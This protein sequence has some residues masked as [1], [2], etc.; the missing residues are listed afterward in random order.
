M[1]KLKDEINISLNEKSCTPFLKYFVFGLIG[2]CLF[3]IYGQES[4]IKCL[5][6]SISIQLILEKL[7]I[8]SRIYLGSCCFGMTEKNTRTFRWGGFWDG[9][10]HLWLVSEFKELIDFTISLLHLHPSNV[11]TNG[12]DEIPPLWWTPIE[13]AIPIFRYLPTDLNVIVEEKLEGVEKLK[14]DKLKKLVEEELNLSLQSDNLEMYDKYILENPD[15]LNRLIEMGNP[16]LNGCLTVVER[17]IPMP[18]WVL[19]KEIELNQK[20][21]KDENR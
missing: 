10:H 9:D 20:I 1:S 6:S 18:D 4:S 16:W 3:K 11:S 15:I 13:I 5:Q 8:K 14:L 21:F 2:K 12:F 7:G 17:E 19:Q